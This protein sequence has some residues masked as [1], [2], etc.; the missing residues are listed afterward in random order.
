MIQKEH[1]TAWLIGTIIG[2]ISLIFGIASMVVTAGVLIGLVILNASHTSGFV[3]TSYSSDF[4][5]L[6]II[7]G[8]VSYLLA[9]EKR[10]VSKGII[11]GIISLVIISIIVI[12]GP[13]G[14]K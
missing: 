4:G 6:A 12:I 8:V 1:S 13:S 7:I 9:R 14:L 5:I 10:F 2:L 3:T 11:L